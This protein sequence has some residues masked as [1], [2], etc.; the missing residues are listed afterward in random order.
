MNTGVCDSIA[1]GEE[2]VIIIGDGGD[3]VIVANVIHEREWRWHEE[4]GLVA[5]GSQDCESVKEEPICGRKGGVVGC[6][7]GMNKTYWHSPRNP[8]SMWRR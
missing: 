2:H 4:W 5:G 3:L 8:R 7:W 1:V 6:R